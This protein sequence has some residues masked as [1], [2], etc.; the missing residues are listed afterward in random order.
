MDGI[1]S[2]ALLGA[3]AVIAPTGQM[4]SLQNMETVLRPHED[5]LSHLKFL[6]KHPHEHRQFGN[7]VDNQRQR[8]GGEA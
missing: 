4:G 6:F 2:P 5:L 3:N 8:A 1:K 7:L